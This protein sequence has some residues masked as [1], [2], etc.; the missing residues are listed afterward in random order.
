MFRSDQCNKGK[1]TPSAKGQPS[2]KPASF[3]SA[4]ILF[5]LLSSATAH[6]QLAGDL[7][8]GQTGLAAGTQAP[9]Q[10]PRPERLLLRLLQHAGS[11]R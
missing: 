7:L 1:K 2:L 6:A 3:A 10:Q 5:A 9:P 11:R 8:K 4:A